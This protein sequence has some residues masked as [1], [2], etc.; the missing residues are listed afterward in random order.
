MEPEIQ[1]G[2][3]YFET[4]NAFRHTSV[5]GFGQGTYHITDDLRATAGFRYT[6]DHN[7][8]LLDNYFGDPNLGGAIVHLHQSSAKLTWKT[9][10]DY[11]VTPDQFALWQ[12][13]HRL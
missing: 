11:Q 8:T 12:R 4:L 1:A 5:S 13:L 10:L 6:T 2:T 9:G 3:L 7:T